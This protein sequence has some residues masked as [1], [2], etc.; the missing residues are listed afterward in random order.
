MNFGLSDQP[1]SEV[2]RQ[3]E[4]MVQ[5]I[6][7]ELRPQREIFFKENANLSKIEADRASVQQQIQLRSEERTLYRLYRLCPTLLSGY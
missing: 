7:D 1:Y 3:S 2:I 5:M 6:E 4:L